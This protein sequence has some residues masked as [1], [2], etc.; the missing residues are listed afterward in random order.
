MKKIAY[1]PI[2]VGLILIIVGIVSILTDIFI[3]DTRRSIWISI[4][5]S[6][7]ASGLVILVQEIVSQTKNP[8]DDWGL[9]KIY[10]TRSEKNADS[11]P[12]LYRI[13]DR[14]DV[15]AFGLKAFR[16][17][18]D[19]EI[20]MLVEKGVMIRILTM[21]PDPENPFLRQRE[22]EECEKEGQIQKG[23]SD[24]VSWAKLINDNHK[25]CGGRI[26]VKGYKCMTL[27][28]Y[29]RMDDELYIGPYWYGLGSQQTI[30]YKYKKGKQGFDLYS[31]Y[32]EKLWNNPENTILLEGNS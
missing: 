3:I 13:K 5:C 29:W 11:D 7:L 28:F 22:K 6:V 17:T 4:G 27:D 1:L 21:N 20:N 16:S 30:T 31:D 15:V 24:L 2:I 8:I 25:R 14:L 19:K 32:F 23:I 9:E 18:H 10:K 12:R 26:S